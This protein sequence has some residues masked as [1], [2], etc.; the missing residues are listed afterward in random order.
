MGLGLQPIADRVLLYGG[1][2]NSRAYEIRDF[3]T[4]CVVNYD[5]HPID[6]DEECMATLCVPMADAHLPVVVLPN[7]TPLSNPT[8]ADIAKHLGWVTRPKLAEYDLSIYGAGPAGLSAAVYAASEGLSVVLIEREAIGGQAG[9]SSLIE[10]YLGFP[11]GIRGADLAER[12]RQQAVAFGAELVL[13]REG[14]RGQF[15]DG[16]IHGE[17]ADGTPIVA[18]SNICA[19]G[20]EWRRL[21]LDGE[22]RLL[23]AGVY[24]GAGTSEASECI[25]EHVFVIG[26]ANSAGQAAMNLAAHARRVTVV[27]RGADLSATM[28]SYLSSRIAAEPRIEVLPHTQVVG[29]IGQEEL[30]AIVLDGPEGRREV[31]TGRLF[32]CIGGLPN[33]DWTLETKIAR[34]RLGY[35]LT[36]PDLDAGLLAERE[37]P[38]ERPPFHLETSVPGS[39]AAGDVR[40]GSVKR[41]ASGVG[42]GAMAVTFVHRYLAE[43][44]GT[45]TQPSS[46]RPGI[47]A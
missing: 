23:G 29:L 14:V 18:R 24:Y 6:T 11:H 32:V 25:D 38:L 10:N 12:A 34:D 7:G 13:M 26:G 47:L 4:R 21:G 19:T 37:W 44:Y 30:E 43:R 28:S 15:R 33:T 16:R 39:F 9:S 17:L 20:I 27:V 31:P 3:L 41:V 40:A 45:T 22:D 46:V 36:G 35:L 8:I 42:E 5:W 1:R 2:H